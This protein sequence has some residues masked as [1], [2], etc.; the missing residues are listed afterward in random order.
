MGADAQTR[1]SSLLSVM[2]ESGGPAGSRNDPLR[3]AFGADVMTL[4][5]GTRALLRLGLLTGNASDVAAGGTE[6]KEMQRKMLL[7]M[8]ADL[9]I[10]LIRLASRLQS[11]RWYAAARVPC[12]R[13][14]ARETMELYTPL[15]NRLGIW[16][17]KWEMEDLAFR[18]LEPDTYKTIARQLEEKRVEREALIAA[19]VEHLKT[20][21]RDARIEGEVHGRPKHIYSIWNKMRN[22]H[23]AFSQL[24][25]LRALRVI[26]EEERD[27]YGVLALVHSLWTP[28]SDEFDDYISRPKPNGYRSLHTVVTD[29]RGRTFEIQIRTREMH[30]FAEYGMAAHWRYKEAGARG[31]Q[32]A[33]AGAYDQK[34]AWMRQLLAWER[35][36]AGTAQPAPD[37]G[38]GGVE[39]QGAPLAGAQPGAG[40]DGREAAGARGKA[41]RGHEARI[42]VLTPQARVIELPEGATPVDFAY[43]L[44][45][46]LGHR[47]RGAKVDGQ[48]V[49]LQT[50]LSTGQTVEI[51][52]AKSG[53]PSR[54]WLNPQLGFLASARSRAKVRAWFNAIE[55]QQRISQGQAM[56]EKELQRL[57]KTAVN[58]E[59]LA[60][61][62]DFA[63]AD[64][65]YVAVAKEEFSLRQI[66]YLLSGRSRAPEGAGDEA[67]SEARIYASGH[68]N[69]LRTGKSGVLVV[70]VDSLL[71]QLARCC[72]PAPPDEIAGFITRGRGVSIHRRDCASYAALAARHPERLIEVDWGNTGDALYPVDIAIHAPDRANLLRDLSEIFA[73]LR[74]KV[75]GVNTHSRRSLAHMVF[76]IE[77]R[78]GEQIKQALLALNELSGV[79]AGRQ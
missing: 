34:I 60:Q 62:L 51:V 38:E 42:Y 33:A 37:E 48:M 13:E 15:A 68:E 77:V 71:T 66:D 9:R 14:F 56:V 4:V 72:R 61:Q 43:H 12:P 47:C 20:A 11:L 76:T 26:V 23:L 2:P 17:I 30:E 70:G 54:D 55:L 18:F 57:G 49:P 69:V 31:G 21:L 59:Q 19:A 32:V 1:A 53:G 50:R 5:Q 46:D 6:Q 52:A 79:S 75:V 78:N 29:T 36:A 22:K 27:C 10:V 73:R 8:A 67:G 25:D 7:A 35:D 45:T 40:N 28:V 64:D 58:M 41:A 39:G 24:Y 63:R 65:L 44:H 16:Q 74:L 3:K